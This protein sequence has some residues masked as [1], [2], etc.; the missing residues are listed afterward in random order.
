[1]QHD[2]R[3]YLHDIV[4]AASSIKKFIED[5]H[6]EEFI[7]NLLV[8][9]AVERQ[10]EIIGEALTRIYRHDQAIA[11][12][13]PKLRDIIDFRNV[14]AHGYDVI[15]HE[16]VWDIIQNHLPELTKKCHDILEKSSP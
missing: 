15:D 1:M 14:I 6:Y 5:V 3:T 10:F 7:N 12:Q 8:R 4:S 9:S 13:I 11:D 16:I 2:S